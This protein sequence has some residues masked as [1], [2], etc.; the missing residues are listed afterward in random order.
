[1]GNENNQEIAVSIRINAYSPPQPPNT[2]GNDASKRPPMHQFGLK[3]PILKIKA[4][5]HLP[6]NLELSRLSKT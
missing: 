6:D 4:Y 1:M 3:P 5:V 2:V